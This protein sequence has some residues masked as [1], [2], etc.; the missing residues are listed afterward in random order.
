MLTNHQVAHYKTFGFLIWHQVLSRDEILR[1]AIELERGLGADYSH[2]PFDGTKKQMATAMGPLTP[3]MASLLEDPRFCDVAEQLGGDDILGLISD[4]NRR[5]GNTFWHADTA[6]IHRCSVKFGWYLDPV[7]ADSGAMRLIPGSHRNPLHDALKALLPY[8]EPGQVPDISVA[9]VPAY[10]CETE[11]G[12]VLI[13][14]PRTWHASVGGPPGRRLCTLFYQS[15]PKTAQEEAGARKFAEGNA[16]TPETHDRPGQPWCHQ[17]W[18]ANPQRSAKR[19]RWINRLRE[20]GF[21]SG[22]EYNF[23]S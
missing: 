14:D 23:L 4:V 1:C 18:V 9:D 3:F 8:P 16:K 17:Q 6:G 5:V 11:P 2:K 20:L 15:N 7:G 19:Q 13:F 12:D 22:N 21:Y 10:A